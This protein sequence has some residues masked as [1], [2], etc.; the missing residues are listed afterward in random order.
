M[1]TSD[2]SELQVSHR[3]L[4]RPPLVSQSE[5]YHMYTVWWW[6]DVC[7]YACVLCPGSSLHVL[8]AQKDNARTEVHGSVR[9]TGA[10]G[11]ARSLH[12][13]RY[14]ARCSYD[15]RPCSHRFICECSGL[16]RGVRRGCGTRSSWV[17][18]LQPSQCSAAVTPLPARAVT[19]S[20]QPKLA[21]AP[22][23]ELRETSAGSG[24]R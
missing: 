20:P 17:L 13:H 15:G 10:S 8:V 21:G 23:F 11:L 16:V 6:S 3:C 18:L 9:R 24:T 7:V 1:I 14:I 22:A 4:C 2:P 12:L 19:A 5:G